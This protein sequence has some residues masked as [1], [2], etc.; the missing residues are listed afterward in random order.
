MEAKS[1]FSFLRLGDR[2]LDF[3]VQNQEN[4]ES[5]SIRSTSADNRATLTKALGCLGLEA[6]HADELQKSYEEADLLDLYAHPH[7]AKNTELLKRWIF[8][9]KNGQIQ[10]DEIGDAGVILDWSVQHLGGILRNNKVL[11]GGAEAEILRCL[12]DDDRYQRSAKEIWTN[13]DNLFLYQPPN[14]GCDLHLYI[15]DIYEAVKALIIENDVRYVFLCLGGAAKILSVRLAKELGVHAIDWGSTLRALTYTGSGGNGI[16]P[17]SHLPFVFRVPLHIYAPALIRAFPEKG[18][19]YYLC[20]ILAQIMFDMHKHVPC[21][22]LPSFYHDPDS[23]VVDDKSLEYFRESME[24]FVGIYYRRLVNTK[25]SREIF[26]EFLD[27]CEKFSISVDR[28]LRR[29]QSILPDYTRADRWPSDQNRA[30]EWKVLR[31]TL[32]G[33]GRRRVNHGRSILIFGQGRSG[34]TLLESLISGGSNFQKNGEILGTHRWKGPKFPRLPAYY[35]K[36]LAAQQKY[37]VSHIKITDLLSRR[38]DVSG[39]LSDLHKA[40]WDLIFLRRLYKCNQAISNFFAESR[41]AFHV[42]AGD[43]PLAD[44]GGIEINPERFVQRVRE[45]LYLEALEMDAMTGISSFPV[46]YEAG[47]ISKE[48]QKETLCR[49][50]DELGF[51]FDFVEPELNKMVKAPLK[52]LVLNWDVIE[53]IIFENNWGIYLDPE[54]I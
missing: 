12:L 46:I 7:Q 50:S 11:I 25:E 10:I 31:T 22:T 20:K 21:Q 24:A 35:V 42:R 32:L 44:A 49:L 41:G 39:F 34:S 53:S 29:Y 5:I 23:V 9:P 38:I 51:K 33:M 8:E 1:P 40:E 4:K 18:N 3:L 30:P 16:W 2:E 47:L 6:Q 15:S 37:L 54:T 19:P 45:R 36:G 52:H 27:W 26:K 17:S 13:L 48:N 28:S 43:K 14:D